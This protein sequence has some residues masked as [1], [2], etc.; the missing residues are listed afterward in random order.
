[1]IQEISTNNKKKKLNLLNLNAKI[2]MIQYKFTIE[3]N[4]KRKTLFKSRKKK[5]NSKK[6]KLI[7]N[8][9]HI[10]K[11]PNKKLPYHISYRNC[12][13]NRTR[14]SNFRHSWVLYN[15]SKYLCTL[16]LSNFIL[17]ILNEKIH[18]FRSRFRFH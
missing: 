2:L 16:S 10:K 7:L 8:F 9:P 15:T 4:L 1:V 13:T 18:I 6:N 12:V 14:L 11:F 3:T 17:V 5:L